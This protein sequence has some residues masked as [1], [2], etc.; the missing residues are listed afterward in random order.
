MPVRG[1]KPGL[2]SRFRGNDGGGPGDC[3][4]KRMKMGDI[5]LADLGSVST[6]GES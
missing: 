2:D 3:H 5:E 6:R 1:S 4:D